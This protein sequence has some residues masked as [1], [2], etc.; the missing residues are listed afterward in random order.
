MEQDDGAEWV[1]YA[2]S[3]ANLKILLLTGSAFTAH[4]R[5]PLRH[6]RHTHA[7]APFEFAVL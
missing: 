6:S 4:A 1:G 2:K 3:S 7:V 5:V